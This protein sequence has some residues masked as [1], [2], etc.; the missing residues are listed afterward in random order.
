MLLEDD[1]RINCPEQP[2]GVYE[3]SGWVRCPADTKVL[4][5]F[6]T[7]GNSDDNV[8]GLSWSSTGGWYKYLPA[9][10][11]REHF[12]VAAL[13][14]KNVHGVPEI[15]L[16]R[17]SGDGEIEILLNERS[18]QLVTM[19]WGDDSSYSQFIKRTRGL[20]TRFPYHSGLV[21]AGQP[22]DAEL[23]QRLEGTSLPTPDG[24]LLLADTRKQVFARLDDFR[25]DALVID[26]FS[27]CPPIV[28]LGNTYIEASRIARAIGLIPLDASVLESGN[29]EYHRILEKSLRDL[30]QRVCPRPVFVQ[31]EPGASLGESN[32]VVEDVNPNLDLFIFQRLSQMGIV[33]LETNS[34]AS[35]VNDSVAI[36][37][38]K[39]IDEYEVNWNA[40]IRRSNFLCSTRLV[41]AFTPINELKE[42]PLNNL[43]GAF[44]I[45]LDLLTLTSYRENNLILTFDIVED[46]GRATER[47]L[48]K[49]SIY[50]SSL[51]GVDYFKYL[52]LSHGS[53]TFTIDVSLPEELRCKGIGIQ[54]VRDFGPVLCLIWRYVRMK[55]SNCRLFIVR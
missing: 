29:I 30:T 33:P 26:W 21:T 44:E 12:K 3:N 47:N 39:Q 51:E 34:E 46:D 9:T 55:L 54:Q 45:E 11:K 8:K 49:Y 43:S 23:Q 27:L 10:G 19:F 5:R 53:E 31:L 15:S 32:D 37:L 16:E 40:G 13:F 1:V 52:P 2:E 18:L 35:A 28:K 7:K 14:E 36:A 50:R 6:R 41:T 24:N 38:D 17:W 48:S 22:W 42:V 25:F 20:V 4:V